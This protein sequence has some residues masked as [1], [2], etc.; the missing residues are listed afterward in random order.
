MRIKQIKL[1][2]SQRFACTPRQVKAAFGP[3]ALEWVSFG[4]PIRTFAFDHRAS[5]APKL[6]GAVVASA[7]V[8]R[9]GL[10]HLCF[11]PIMRDGYPDS[12]ASDF[13]TSILPSLARWISEMHSRPATAIVGVEE[14]V[15][16]WNGSDH[17]VHRLT[18]L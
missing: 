9:E 8:N 13:A 1:P 10:A 12:A 2:V 11:F 3:A 15:I 17:S 6:S 5:R 16:E 18:F 14:S 7:Q 4:N